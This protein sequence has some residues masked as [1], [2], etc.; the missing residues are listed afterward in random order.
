VSLF[1]PPKKK[2]VSKISTALALSTTELENLRKSVDVFR[3]GLALKK[4]NRFKNSKTSAEPP[5]GV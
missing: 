4:K 1:L 3:S 5:N 2:T